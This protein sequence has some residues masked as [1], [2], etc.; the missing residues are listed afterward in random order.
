MGYPFREPMMLSPTRVRFLNEERDVSSPHAWHDQ[1]GKKLWLYNLHYFEDLNARNAQMRQSWHENLMRRWIAENPPGVG[2]GWDPY[3]LSQRITNWIKWALSGNH[4]SPEAIHSLA[5][6]TRYLRRRYDYHLLGNHLLVNGRTF[7]FAGLFFEGREAD[8]WLKKGLQILT[9]QIPEQIL[10]D[11]GHFELC[12]MY[13]NLIIEDFLDLLNLLRL[14]D[15]E[16]LF[17]WHDELTRM[18]RWA[19][20]MAHPD[21]QIAL[22]NDAAFG[23][24]LTAA[25]LE[26]YARPLG[27]PALAEPTP[28]LVSLLPSGFVRAARGPVVLFADVGP[29]GADYLPGHGHADSLSF[30]L[31]LN[32]RRVIVDSGTSL[33][34]IVPERLRQR[35]TGAHNTV[36]IDGE[37]SSEVWSSFRV[38]RRAKISGVKVEPEGISVRIEA[39]HDGYRR[40][41]GCG[42]HRRVWLLSD[43]DL[44]I[45]DLIEGKKTHTVEL[46]FHFHPDAAVSRRGENLVEV[47]LG[48][49]KLARLELDK[50]LK[51]RIEE[52][53]YHPGFGISLE[54]Q[55]VT[56]TTSE[57][58]PLTLMTTFVWY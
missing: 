47:E 18:R 4:L 38:A 51:I 37:D 17:R 23:I 45:H 54:S 22:F 42:L 41:S 5:V 34:D 32:G 2:C 27:L 49:G 9:D 30:E 13:H 15:R 40:L 12:P 7:V 29:I 46:A 28:D 26:D 58:L 33:Y 31:S 43:K 10:P 36:Q 19:F 14:Y 21:G 35:G 48:G 16:N 53:T 8:E 44:L 11:G 20:D 52:S 50:R 55:R 39:A 25:Q 3:P 56:A 24:A 57:K 1:P 6:Q